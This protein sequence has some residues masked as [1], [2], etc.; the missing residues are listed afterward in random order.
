MGYA[1]NNFM[2]PIQTVYDTWSKA[3]CTS[4]FKKIT[5]FDKGVW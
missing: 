3:H 2:G 4:E 1:D 5:T